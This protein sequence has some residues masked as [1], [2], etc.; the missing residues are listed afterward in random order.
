MDPQIEDDA[1][2]GT[3]SASFVVSAA[4]VG[5]TFDSSF[6]VV[7]YSINDNNHQRHNHH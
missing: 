6:L 4:Y 2:P 7:A 1:D 5:E 3:F